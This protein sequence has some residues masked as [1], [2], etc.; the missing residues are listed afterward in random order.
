MLLVSHYQVALLLVAA[1]LVEVNK[2][3]IVY[4]EVFLLPEPLKVLFTENFGGRRASVAD[5]INN[6]TKSFSA[7]MT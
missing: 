2:S 3:E 4:L 7:G 1:P 6:L 5:S